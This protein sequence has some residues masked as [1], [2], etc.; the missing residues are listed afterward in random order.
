MSDSVQSV[1]KQKIPIAETAVSQLSG[2]SLRRARLAWVGLA[3]F[4]AVI[5]VMALPGYALKLNGQLNHVSPASQ[6]TAVML[7]G[8]LSGLVSLASA[9]LSFG[10]SWMFFRRQ[11]A[12]PIVAALS[13]YLLTFAIVM[14]GP[15][16]VWSY[17]WLDGALPTETIQGVL[18]TTPTIALF[19]LFPNGRF[20]PTW[21]RWV[22]L[23]TIP[24]N[25]LLF[26]LPGFDGASLSLL[27]PLSL[28][29]LAIGYF[30]ILSVGLYAQIYRYR[31]I[32]S[33]LERQ[34]TRWVVFGF[35]IWLGYMILSTW[36]YVYITNLPPGNPTPWWVPA[37]EFGWF[38]SLNIVPVTLSI[39]VTRYRL[40]DIRVVINRTLVYGLLMTC[41]ATIYV[42]VVGAVSSLIQAQGNWLVALLATGLVAVLFQPLREWLQR[43]VNRLIYGQ[44]DEPFEVLTRLGQQ[45]AGTLSPEMV[46]PTIVETVAQTLKLPYVA[47]AVREGEGFKT[48]VSFG[49][50]TLNL[51]MYPLMYQQDIVGQLQVAQRAPNE[52]FTQADERLLLSISRQAGTAVHVVQLTADLQRSRQRLVT[53][54]EEERRRLRRDLHDGLGPTLAAHMLKLGSIRALLTHDSAS[55]DS[56][57]DQLETDIE[58]TLTEVRRL[59]YNLRPPALDQLGLIGAIGAYAAECE[60]LEAIQGNQGVAITIDAPKKLPALPAAV[61]VAAY[62]ISRE[63]LTNVLRHAQATRCTIT[64][65]LVENQMQSGNGRLQLSIHDNGSGLPA[66]LQAGVGLS[67]MRERVEEVGGVFKMETAVGHGL[68]IVAEMPLL[69]V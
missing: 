17:Y 31:H 58:D 53:T 9:L 36:P 7:F 66:A 12:E 4:A 45:L 55:A 25:V 54:R 29:L 27:G 30:S 50:P 14:A 8:V 21:T 48:A 35:A 60:R 18:L 20:V 44:R 34:Q 52:S 46:Y 67:S 5:L 40:W 22:L 43:W 56:L 26:I 62:Y 49:K 19:F 69:A 28:G 13:F 23:I 11:F 10:L 64:L 16:E 32:S 63:G 41:A 3:F 1:M 65:A 59:V 6:T 61:E 51:V 2:T 42:V 57:L 38:L 33:P 47:I 24:W 39:A 15:L 37:S 68:Q